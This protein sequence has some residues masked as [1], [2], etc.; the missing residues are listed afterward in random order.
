[1][2]LLLSLLAIFALVSNYSHAQITLNATDFANAVD[3]VRL[4]STTD[5][6][7]DLGNTGPNVTWDFSS[8]TANSQRLASFLP[9]SESG[10]LSSFVFGSTAPVNYRASYFQAS[11]AI[12]LDLIGGFLPIPLEDIYLYSKKNTDSITSIGYA[13]L[14]SGNEVPVKS[15]TIETFYKY[16]LTYLDSYQS[17]GYTFLN[18]SPFFD[19]QWIQQRGHFTEVDGWGSLTTVLGTFDAIRVVHTIDESDSIQYDFLGTGTPMWIGIP[20]PKRKI[21]EWWTNGKKMPMVTITTTEVA[22]TE[23]IASIEYQDEYL[24]F[25]VGIIETALN[26]SI[27]PNPTTD[28][29]I[30]ESSVMFDRYYVYNEQGQIVKSGDI[31]YSNVDVHDLIPGHYLLFLSSTEGVSSHRFIKN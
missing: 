24:G 27:G 23:T 29:L 8:F 4:S 28:F 31:Q 25:D 5:L 12:P 11:D 26:S 9:M 16:P 3:T 6:T 2:K 19:A 18:M 30:V 13:M 22:G 7:V 14:V 20:V 10:F 15:D 21:Y 1:M 17:R